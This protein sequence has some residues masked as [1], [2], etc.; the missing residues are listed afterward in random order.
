[1]EKVVTGTALPKKKG[2]KPCLSNADTGAVT[3]TAVSTRAIQHYTATIVMGTLASES[4]LTV[5]RKIVI[6]KS[7]RVVGSDSV[8][9]NF[10]SLSNFDEAIT[11]E[12]PVPVVAIWT[13]IEDTKR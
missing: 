9:V 3:I 12:L 4:C 2:Q 10:F 7:F 1:M 8:N 6:D 11:V 13:M 5:Y